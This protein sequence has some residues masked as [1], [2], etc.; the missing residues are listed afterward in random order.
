MNIR[1]IF[2]IFLFLLTGCFDIEFIN[3]EPFSD[4][5]LSNQISIIKAEEVMN[6]L[7]IGDKGYRKWYFIKPELLYE[8]DLSK[9]DRSKENII[10]VF[11]ETYNKVNKTDYN[12]MIDIEV[13]DK[14]SYYP[15]G[16]TEC[17]IVRGYLVKI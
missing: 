10:K 7:Y 4:I 12:A 9:F 13:S 15:Y 17:Y 8:A 11:I 16:L 1:Y 2:L 5:Y 6:R 14:E 3:T